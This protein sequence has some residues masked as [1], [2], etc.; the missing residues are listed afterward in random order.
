MH[1]PHHQEY[2]DIADLPGHYLREV[3]HF[4]HIYKDLEGKRVEILG[5]EKSDS[6][7][8]LILESIARYEAKYGVRGPA[9]EAAAPVLS[10]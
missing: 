1:D 6:A 3:E 5:W 2:F 8:R 10:R 7:M 4:F 9:P